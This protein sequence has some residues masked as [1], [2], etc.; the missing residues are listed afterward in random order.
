MVIVTHE[1]KTGTDGVL[2]LIAASH[3]KPA[4]MK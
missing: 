4:L 3:G 1:I 2:R